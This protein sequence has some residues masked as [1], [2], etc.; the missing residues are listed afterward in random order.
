MARDR[1]GLGWTL[2]GAGGKR[3]AAFLPWLCHRHE[4]AATEA[5]ASAQSSFLQPDGISSIEAAYP[6]CEPHHLAAMNGDCAPDWRA[7]LPRGVPFLRG[8]ALH[9]PQLWPNVYGVLYI[10]AIGTLWTVQRQVSRSLVPSLVTHWVYN[11]TLM[12]FVI[13]STIAGG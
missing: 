4:D 3:G 9:A 2:P 1:P 10:L 6:N 8:A 7:C 5:A 11:A 12:A 13:A